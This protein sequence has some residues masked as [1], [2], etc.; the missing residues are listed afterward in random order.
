MDHE[1]T[2]VY[3]A[4]L[5]QYDQNYTIV[6]TFCSLLEDKEELG[7]RAWAH[8]RGKQHITDVA[9][10]DP[11]FCVGGS[12]TVDAF[13]MRD[14]PVL[15]AGR[16]LG[17]T[18]AEATDAKKLRLIMFSATKTELGYSVL[19]MSLESPRG[20]SRELLTHD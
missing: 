11:V 4:T 14:E 17:G 19:E 8:V 6:Y 5:S 20:E 7:Q 15:F 16:F 9:S 13:G 2:D 3:E 10:S 12:V 1:K 18:T